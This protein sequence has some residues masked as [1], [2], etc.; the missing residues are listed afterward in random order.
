MN[1]YHFTKVLI[2]LLVLIIAPIQLSSQSGVCPD[3]VAAALNSA[4]THCLNTGRN[5]LCYGNLSAEATPQTGVTN[6]RFE[7]VGDVVSLT[8]LDTLKLDP[9]DIDAGTWG[10]ALMQLQAN[11]PDTI[12]GQNVTFLIFGDV[13]LENATQT[14]MLLETT[15][16]MRGQMR[17]TPAEDD[18][19]II[20]TIDANTPV[21]A[22]GRDESGRWVRIRQDWT[23]AWVAVD[24]LRDRRDVSNLP[25]VEVDAPP[26]PT[27][28]QAFYFQTG[29]GDRPCAE[30]PDS[31]MLI[32]TPKGVRGVTFTAN[33][34]VISLGSSAYLRLGNRELKMSVVE[35]VGYMTA[36]DVTQ[37]VPAGTFVTVPMSED[38]REPIAPPNYPIPY[39]FEAMSVLPIARDFFETQVIVP[40]LPEDQIP[41]AIEAIFAGKPALSGIYN[42]VVDKVEAEEGS[43]CFDTPGD[44]AF[45]QFEFLDDGIRV[46]GIET[47]DMVIPKVGDGVYEFSIT[48]VLGE[49]RDY[50]DRTYTLSESVRVTI[51]V[52]SHNTLEIIVVNDSTTSYV[53]SDEVTRNGCTTYISATWYAP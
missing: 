52:K 29:I 49:Y 23:G 40:T 45:A 17:A 46:V 41:A 3:I 24:L 5:T 31:G 33:G 38:G 39:N 26:P 43:E 16:R 50:E 22:Y 30:A 36:F 51:M 6:F 37:P 2:V 53:D 27:P 8:D 4:E 20:G 47:S 44:S 19:N 35:G 1:K 28:M 7:Q 11:L 21:V 34:V 15:T 25:V 10:V 18:D 13:S 42:T 9:M 32:Q 12:P 48:Q 14:G